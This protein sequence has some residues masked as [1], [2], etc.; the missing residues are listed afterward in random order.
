MPSAIDNAKKALGVAGLGLHALEQ[1]GKIAKAAGG[2][3]TGTNQLVDALGVIAK[4]VDAV[5]G[6]LDGTSSLDH[7]EAEITK[8][9]ASLADNDASARSEVDAKFGK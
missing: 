5:R 1:I 6:G 2:N 9:A 8:L 4:L 3:A 7:I